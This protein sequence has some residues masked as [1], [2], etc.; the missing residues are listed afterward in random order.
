MKIEMQTEKGKQEELEIWNLVS[1][2]IKWKIIK[3]NQQKDQ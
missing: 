2:K 1:I 3:I